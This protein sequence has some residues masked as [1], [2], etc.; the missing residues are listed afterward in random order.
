MDM[1]AWHKLIVTGYG[2]GLGTA[3]CFLMFGIAQRVEKLLEKQNE[4]LMKL[5]EK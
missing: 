5:V 3:F 2:V 4:H 1:D